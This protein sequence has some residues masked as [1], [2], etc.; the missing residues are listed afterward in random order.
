MTGKPVAEKLCF[1]QLAEW[2]NEI[3]GKLRHNSLEAWAKLK[4]EKTTWSIV[5]NVDVH[6]HDP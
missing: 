3:G 5:G 6:L 2:Q 1:K 4:K